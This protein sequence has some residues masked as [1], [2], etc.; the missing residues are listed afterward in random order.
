MYKIVQIFTNLE[1][2]TGLEDFE[3]KNT[4]ELIA[5]TTV[6]QNYNSHEYGKSRDGY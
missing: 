1:A 5:Q 4:F 2:L 3:K 6:L